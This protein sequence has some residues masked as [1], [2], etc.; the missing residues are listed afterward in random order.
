MRIKKGFTL[1]ELL[2]V[3]AIIL[4]LI[5]IALPNFLEAQIRAKVAKAK[6]EMRSIGIAMESY[7]L[8]FKIYPRDHERHAWG[9]LFWLTAPI[10]YIGN[11]PSDAFF[12]YDNASAATAGDQGR[13]VT[14][15]LGGLDAGP[16]PGQGVYPKCHT[17][18]L[19]WVLHS[20]GPDGNEEP[21]N[22]GDPHYGGNNRTYSPTNGTKSDGNILTF[23]GDSSYIGMNMSY[24][25]PSQLHA[26]HVRAPLMLDGEPYIKRLPPNK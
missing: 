21:F 22:Q 8:D 24:A 18:Q 12:S 2:I 23:G 5:A 7:N 1:I 15:E 17:C 9:G 16:A 25:V 3:I 20:S 19:V 6:G 4:I 11:M 14:Y 26:P 13:L 10:N